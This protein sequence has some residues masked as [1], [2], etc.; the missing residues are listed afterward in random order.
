MKK[1]G[2]P[3]ERIIKTAK[4]LDKALS[5]L[6]AALIA[7]SVITVCVSLVLIATVEKITELVNQSEGYVT[8]TSGIL[9][10]RLK[11]PAFTTGDIR[12]FLITVVVITVAVSIMA[13]LTV[14]ILKGIISGMKEGHPFSQDMPARIR[15]LAY[16]IFA[17]AA[18]LPLLQFISSYFIFRLID[19]QKIL[20]ESPL[21]G[22]VEV[23]L[24][25][26]ISVLA[27]LLGFVVILLSLV[28]E[29]GS[30]LQRESDETL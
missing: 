3:V 1:E 27:V 8:V 24:D 21:V 29:Y 12:A 22:K 10:M 19:V 5:V 13:L 28:F 26:G 4:T 15:R 20:S 9:K 6:R 25:F 18:A 30:L 7:A 14:N 16:M 2:L 11:N 17:Y 23:S